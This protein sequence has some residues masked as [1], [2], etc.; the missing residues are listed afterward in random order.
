MKID[1]PEGFGSGPAL[2]CKT[3]PALEGSER[4]WSHREW[5]CHG[6]RGKS[7]A[8][9]RGKCLLLSCLSC[10]GGINNLSFIIQLRNKLNS[11]FLYKNPDKKRRCQNTYCRK[12]LMPSV[13]LKSVTSL[14]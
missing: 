6:R 11:S 1:K 7:V 2:L 14:I 8:K 10:G 9:D 13:K 5:L 3:F 4:L 12:F